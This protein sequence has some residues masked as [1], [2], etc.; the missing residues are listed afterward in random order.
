MRR[1]NRRI[2]DFVVVVVVVVIVVVAVV[3]VVVVV[4]VAVV[5]VVTTE[6][7]LIYDVPSTFFTSV[8]SNCFADAV[9]MIN[10]FPIFVAGNATHKSLC[11]FVGRLVVP[12]ARSVTLY[13]LRI[14]ELIEGGKVQI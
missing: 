13:F 12:L 11:R 5:V 7:R 8:A 10:G 14:F 3:V 4:V 9:M 2:D 1:T 6:S